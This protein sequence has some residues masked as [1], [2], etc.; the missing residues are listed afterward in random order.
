MDLANKLKSPVSAARYLGVFLR[1]NCSLYEL[2][3]QEF[4]AFFKIFATLRETGFQEDFVLKAGHDKAT[5]R[6]EI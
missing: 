5:L 4:L 1:K 2:G 3:Y 6:A